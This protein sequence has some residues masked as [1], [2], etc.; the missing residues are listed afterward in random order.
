MSLLND[1]GMV[2]A[3]AGQLAETGDADMSA[4][5][6]ALVFL[7]FIWTGGPALSETESEQ[8][9]DFISDGTPISVR[10]GEFS[11]TP[12]SGPGGLYAPPQFDAV[13]ADSPRG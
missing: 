4:L 9:F 12:P 3:A 2:A 10:E 5:R 11:I 8:S 7:A 13:D 1:A 6:A